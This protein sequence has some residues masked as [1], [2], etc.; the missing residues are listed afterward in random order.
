MRM[1]IRMHARTHKYSRANTARCVVLDSDA[2]TDIVKQMPSIEAQR[3]S[4]N[5]RL[6]IREESNS[7]N[8]PY[9]RY[10]GTH[11]ASDNTLDEY[12]IAVY[13]K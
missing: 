7:S 5:Y 9:D 4:V 8:L 6:D 12:S 10:V 1:Y 11:R 3:L 13:P 2:I